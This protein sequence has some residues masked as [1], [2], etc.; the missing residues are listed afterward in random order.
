V[1]YT[2]PW[3]FI[4]Q[5]WPIIVPWICLCFIWGRLSLLARW[6]HLAIPLL[7]IFF[8][9]A[10]FGDR[11]LTIEKNWG[12]IY[13]A[14]LVTFLPLVFI[15]KNIPF[16]LVTIVFLFISVIFF[17]AWGKKSVDQ[18]WSG[19]VLHLRGDVAIVVDP[20]KQR[21]LQVLERFHGVTVLSGKSAEAYNECPSMVGFSENMCYIAWFFQEYQC[22]HGGEAEFRDKQSNDFFAGTMTNPLAFL[23]NNNITA[24]VVWPEDTIPDNIV[25][26]LQT[27]LSADYYYIDCKGDGPNN[28]GVFVRNPSAPVYG[29]N[30][31]LPLTPTAPVAPVPAIP[32]PAP[33][34]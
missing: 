24:V 12:A 9:V 13:G 16:R 10:T 7:L 18:A 27:Q 1:E 22:G 21:L 5:W 33:A 34:K 32:A 30:L 28:A 29:T 25:Q 4:I 20:Q 17:G 15:Q 26:Q 31:A 8:E 3:E 11:G 19:N 6:I 2:A 23:R 14:G